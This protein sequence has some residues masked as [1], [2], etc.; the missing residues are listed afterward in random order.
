MCVCVSLSEGLEAS[1]M[2]LF[3][4][5]IAYIHLHKKN[6]NTHRHNTDKDT[7]NDLQE[8]TYTVEC[9]NSYLNTETAHV[10]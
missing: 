10:C 1:E 2:D 8:S 5:V 3:E 6:T 9:G 7:I 4:G